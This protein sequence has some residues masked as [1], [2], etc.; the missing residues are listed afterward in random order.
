MGAAIAS[1]FFGLRSRCWK[2]W[3]PFRMTLTSV[4]P[5]LDVATAAATLA[6]SVTR[7]RSSGW[8]N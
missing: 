7:A 6:S 8:R 2:T 1:D 5:W 3:A 4:T